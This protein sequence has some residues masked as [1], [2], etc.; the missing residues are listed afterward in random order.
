MQRAVFLHRVVGVDR[1]VHDHLLELRSVG[2]HAREAGGAPRL[3]ADLVPD[4]APQH[5]VRVGDD[6]VE[7][8][9]LRIDD[10]LA[11]E[12]QQLTHE[13]SGALGGCGDLLE[14]LA[15]RAVAFDVETSELDVPG[16][17]GEDVVEVVGDAAG[18]P[19]EHLHLLRVQQLLLEQPFV[20]DVT[21]RGEQGRLT[22]PIEA[23]H[24]GFDVSQAV[25]P[26]HAK[27]GD[28]VGGKWVTKRAVHQRLDR[29][30]E[31]GGGGG[32]GELNQA[33]SV[34]DDQA[35]RVGRDDAKAGLGRLEVR[36]QAMTLDRVA[37]RTDQHVAGRLG[38]HQVILGPVLDRAD[39][40]LGVVQTGQHDDRGVRRG[41]VD[42]AKRVEPRA[43]RQG[44][45]EQHE[46]EGL[47]MHGVHRVVEA[48]DVG[49]RELGRPDVDQRFGQ[50]ARVRGVVLDEEDTDRRVR[51]EANIAV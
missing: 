15:E 12:R 36:R 3:D 38:L 29:A 43:V 17:P 14:A 30:P 32:V 23:L 42:R 16:D 5:L 40:E 8:E 19:A 34:D 49:Q 6:R 24:A 27:L 33:V 21:Q 46:I 26:A 50:Q 18:Q 4:E 28:L 25:L 20:G 1:E 48:F 51:H 39:R 44:Q 13:L 37:H 31:D 2:E 10:L 11:R 7:V 22:F 9:D 35:V 47:A 45:I 41:A